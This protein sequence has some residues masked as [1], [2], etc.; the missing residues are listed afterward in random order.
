MRPQSSDFVLRGTFRTLRFAPSYAY[1]PPHPALRRHQP[2]RQRDRRAKMSLG[3]LGGLYQFA[4]CS[5]VSPKAKPRVGG[6]VLPAT[7]SRWTLVGS[8][9]QRAKSGGV[10]TSGAAPPR[11]AN[12]ATPPRIAPWRLHRVATFPL[13]T[14][15]SDENQRRSADVFAEANYRYGQPA[16]RRRRWSQMA[17]SGASSAARAPLAPV[18]LNLARVLGG[19]LGSR[20]I[21]RPQSASAGRC[22]R[23][24]ARNSEQHP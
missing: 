8:L 14:M 10:P 22:A 9:S 13:V 11:R 12:A 7:M 1:G 3:S 16:W 24:R 2:R 6:G 17:A 21:A 5:F 18:F 15:V 23:V 20:V 19:R 4:T